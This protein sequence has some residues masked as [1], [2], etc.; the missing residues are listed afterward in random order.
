MD[1]N[2]YKA[3]LERQ[4]RERA[5]REKNLNETRDERARKAAKAEQAQPAPRPSWAKNEPKPSFDAA[6]KR[7]EH[8]LAIRDRQELAALDKQHASER[9]HAQSFN[10]RADK[11]LEFYEDIHKM[12]VPEQAEPEQKQGGLQFHEDLNP[13]SP[14]HTIKR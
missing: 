3:M 10:A 8:N 14:G 11:K 2:R 7:N 5:E 13:P 12:K 1:P 9:D 6:V 4:E